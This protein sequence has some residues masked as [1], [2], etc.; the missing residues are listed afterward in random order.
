MV[1]FDDETERIINEAAERAV[2]FYYEKTKEDIA[3]VLEAT[4]SIK[5]QLDN[6]ITRDEFNEALED[7]RLNPLA[8]V[9]INKD[10]GK[11]DLRVTKLEN[12]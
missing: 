6:M 2:G 1:T 10:M 5:G 12:A 9:E 11:L 3:L 4:D 7:I 8:T